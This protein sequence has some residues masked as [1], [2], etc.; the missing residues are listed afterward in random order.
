MVGAAEMRKH[1]VVPRLAPITHV[2]P[3]IRFAGQERDAFLCLGSQR[4]RGEISWQR[5]EGEQVHDPVTLV[6]PSVNAQPD[7]D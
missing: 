6:I 4:E 3:A 2:A 5:G 1:D 7:E